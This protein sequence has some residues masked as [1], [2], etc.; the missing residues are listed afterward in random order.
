MRAK[1]QSLPSVAAIVPAAGSGTRFGGDKLFAPLE[2]MPVLAHTLKALEHSSLISEIVPVTRKEKEDWLWRLVKEYEITKVKRIARG[3][4]QRQDS[5]YNG[6]KALSETPDIVVI[7]DGARP[8]FRSAMIEGPILALLKDKGGIHGIVIGVPV[9]DTIKVLHNNVDLTVK[10]TL[11]R[12]LLWIAQTPQIF[13]YSILI[14]AL[15]RA[16][17]EG[18]YATDD[19]ALVE[20][21]GGVVRMYLGSYD[22]IKITTKEDLLIG[23]CI[24]SNPSV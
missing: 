6:V 19:S 17:E 22:N 24:F 3:G 16:S 14:E 15:Q 23:S 9:K 10:S 11:E 12:S 8:L 7:H 4:L 2:E 21:Y 18:F 20:R 5:V 13:Y 1:V